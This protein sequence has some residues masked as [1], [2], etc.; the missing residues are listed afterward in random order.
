MFRRTH[1][2][3]VTDTVTLQIGPELPAA[4]AKM[5][6]LRALDLRANRLVSVPPSLGE[7]ANRRVCVRV[8]RLT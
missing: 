8:C 5:H 6:S 1:R 3:R 2:N 7:L 4:F